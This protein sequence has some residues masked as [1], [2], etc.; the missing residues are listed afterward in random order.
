[1]FTIVTPTDA[2]LVS[3]SSNEVDAGYLEDQIGAGSNKITLTVTGEGADEA[4]EIDVDQT[5]IIP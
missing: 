3:I 5:K 1:M 4:L 2:D